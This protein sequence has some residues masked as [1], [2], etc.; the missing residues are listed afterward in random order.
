MKRLREDRRV[1]PAEKCAVV[2]VLPNAEGSG[3][4]QMVVS[5]LYLAAVLLRVNDSR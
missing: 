5:Q 3:Q 2:D 1:L 4:V